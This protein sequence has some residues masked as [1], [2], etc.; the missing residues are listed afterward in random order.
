MIDLFADIDNKVKCYE[1]AVSFIQSIPRFSASEIQPEDRFRMTSDL[2][3]YMKKAGIIEERNVQVFH[4]AGTNGKGSVCAFL[5]SMHKS[6]G[7]NTGVFTSPHLTD[8]RERIATDEGMISKDDFYRIFMIIVSA[9]GEFKKNMMYANYVPV[10][11]D[12]LFFIAA[13]YFTE[14]KP[15]A[16]IWETG[17][18]GSL[19]ST[20]VIGNKSVAVITEIGMDHMEILGN[21]IEEIASQKAGII[22]SSVPVV[23]VGKTETA[24]SVIKARAE[25]Y[26]ALVTVVPDHEHIVKKLTDKRIDFS[27]KSRYYNNATLAVVGHAAYQTENASLAIAAMECVYSQEILSMDV[28]RNGL[29]SMRWAGR[30]E[31]IED[32]V[33][34]DGAHNTDGIDALI[35]SVRYDGCKGRR[36]MLF[37][38]VSDKQAD[39]MLESIAGSGLFYEVGLTPI[40]NDRG[41]SK[42][43]LYEFGHIFDGYDTNAVIY[44]E[45]TSAYDSLKEGIT[46]E[47]VLY[48]CGSLYLVGEL[49]AYIEKKR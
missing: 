36:F 44:D 43:T 9:Y 27:Y 37:S 11:F 13:V 48:V 49:K 20:N 32:N 46:K 10:Y 35:E 17:L 12:W 39:L 1:D 18:G 22:T 24:L 23:T 2:Y 40:H 28:I 3:S 7:L 14:K 45:L 15:D 33:F 16:V 25:E 29:L 5:R 4:V 6:M 38:A 19:D 41:V 42:D 47:D 34:F 26:K 8:I 21:D 31:K 30:M